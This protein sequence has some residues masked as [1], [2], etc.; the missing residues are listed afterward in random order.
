MRKTISYSCRKK[1]LTQ[2]RFNFQLANKV[3]LKLIPVIEI[4]KVHQTNE[5]HQF[6]HHL[7]IKL[8]CMIK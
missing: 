2:R 1:C 6:Y 5:N 4:L 8:C 7:P 3:G